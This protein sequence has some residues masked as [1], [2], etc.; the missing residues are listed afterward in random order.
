MNIL[1]EIYNGNINPSEKFVKKDG[2]YGR[3]L[4]EYAEQ[5]DKLTAMLDDDR[6]KLLESIL[7]T[8]GAMEQISHKESFIEGFCLGAGIMLEILN[9]DLTD[10]T[11]L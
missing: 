3:L 4:N 11:V 2:E 10:R 8:D 6:K 5:M 1:E 7:E 9:R